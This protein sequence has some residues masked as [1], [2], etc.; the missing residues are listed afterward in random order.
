MKEVAL[1]KKKTKN[2]G[3]NG[4]AYTSANASTEGRSREDDD[5]S[6]KMTLKQI[7]LCISSRDYSWKK[8]EKS[9]REKRRE[10]K[11]TRSRERM[12]EKKEGRMGKNRKI[13]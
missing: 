13:N 4:D 10:G 12:K 11:I 3:S 2:R 7:S 5:H 1:K 8:W 9:K 6:E